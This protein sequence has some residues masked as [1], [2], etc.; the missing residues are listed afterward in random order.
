[1]D[2]GLEGSSIAMLQF[3]CV[4][5]PPGEMFG[6]EIHHWRVWS[7]RNATGYGETISGPAFDPWLIEN[8]ETHQK[9]EAEGNPLEDPF[10]PD[11]EAH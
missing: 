3:E 9:R 10:N 4:F 6:G 5:H 7:G 11:S 8:N 2:S 1:M